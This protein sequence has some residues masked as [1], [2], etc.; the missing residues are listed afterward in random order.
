MPQRKGEK[1]KNAPAEIDRLEWCFGD[2]P[3]DELFDCWIYEFARELGWLREFVAT[4]KA[5]KLEKLAQATYYSFLLFPQWPAKP[6]LSVE[7]SERRRI[8]QSVRPTM[9]ELESGALLSHDVPKGVEQFLRTAL[10]QSGRPA[11]KS[12]TGRMEIALFRIDW[13]FSDSVL[14]RFFESYLELNRPTEIEPTKHRAKNVPD[15]KRRQQLKELGMYRLIRAN[16]NSVSR[17]RGTGNLKT[18]NA[19]PWYDAQKNIESLLSSA[20][21]EIFPKVAF[22]SKQHP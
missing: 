15:A 21:T 18:A 11:I 22:Q 7:P 17:A 1:P 20:S 16:G 12:K 19:Q 10:N 2:C 4:Q 8:V 14:L 9:K 3:S 5:K 6:Y 13:Q